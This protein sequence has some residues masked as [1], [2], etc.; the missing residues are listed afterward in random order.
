VAFWR[1]VHGT[2]TYPWEAVIGGLLEASDARNKIYGTLGVTDWDITPDYTRTVRQV[3]TEVAVFQI[4]EDLGIVLRR[5]GSPGMAAI[6]HE[7]GWPSWVPDL[8]LE[9]SSLH[10]GHI[11]SASKGCHGLAMP[12]VQGSSLHCLGI[13]CET[14]TTVELVI[15]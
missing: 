13:A 4:G 8:R 10:P 9:K 7:T 6:D 5:S 15:D 14:I 11:Y 1:L 3:Y 2:E 12:E